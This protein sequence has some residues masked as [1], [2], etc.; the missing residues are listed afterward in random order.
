VGLVEVIEVTR[1]ARAEDLLWEAHLDRPVVGSRHGGDALEI[2]GWVVGRDGPVVAVEVVQG[3][4]VVRRVPPN[5]HRPDLAA[6]FPAVSYATQGGF[7]LR[8]S[9]LGVQPEVVFEVRA[10]LGDQ[11]RVALGTIRTRRLWREEE[12]RFGGA[13]V[14]VIIPCYNQ[15][16]FLGEALA[17]VLGQTY[18]HLEVVVIDDG[19]TDNTGEVAARYPGV[20]CI[21]QSNQGRAEA[22]NAGLRQSNGEYLAFLDADDRLLPEAL[23]TGLASLAAHPASGFTSGRCRFIAAD[24]SPLDTPEFDVPVSALARDPYLAL[25]ER[26]H[27]WAGSG[28][29]YRRSLFEAVGGFDPTVG[30]C[31]DYDLYLRVTRDYPVSWHDGVVS[32]YR[33]H[34]TNT[35]QNPGLMLRSQ[36]TVLRR[37]RQYAGERGGPYAEALRRGIRQTQR[38]YYGQFLVDEVQASIHSRRWGSALYGLSVLLRYHPQGFWQVAQEVKRLLQSTIGQRWGT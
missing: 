28:V 9:V 35:T 36:V 33:K 37:Q 30:V 10:V 31:D 24:G 13:L 29:M 27:I 11:R 32:E 17:S 2:M 23:E 26:C 38:E 8:V 15:A 3:D 21:R 1:A 4:A 19:S 18:P 22:R 14:S 34:G 5:H 25:L 12:A 7:R 16:H 6:A 20:R